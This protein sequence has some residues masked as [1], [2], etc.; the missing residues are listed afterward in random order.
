MNIPEG[1]FDLIYL[2]SNGLFYPNKKNSLLIKYLTAKEEFVLTSPSFR[3]GGKALKMVLES[4]IIDKDIKVE[5][6]LVADKEAIIL[7]LRSTAYGDSFPL[8]FEC[9]DCH[10]KTN[11][12]LNISSLEMVDMHSLPDDLGEFEYTLPMSK[13][14]VKFKPLTV[15]DEE[16]LEK[17][18]RKKTIQGV[19]Y[20]QEITSKYLLQLT[21]IDEHREKSY[22]ESFIK[23]MSLK[24]SIALREYIERTEPGINKRIKLVCS[25]CEKE[26]YDN[27][28]ISSDFLGIT[29]EYRKNIDEEIFLLCYY[30]Q[31][32]Y[33]REQVLKMSVSERKWAIQRISEE[34]E[35]K[36]KAE[37]DAAKKA[38]GS[39]KSG[40][41]R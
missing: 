22:I 16:L 15:A 7:F 36:N 6:L 8:E 28:N 40:R 11:N 13:S 20:K 5:E 18:S 9:S 31:G 25:S 4:V 39:S 12:P 32:G 35:K 10:A 41:T 1:I 33:D 3:E 2:P 38:K 23:R 17:N 37:A 30:G 27:L 29:P 14:K 24:D 21:E 26:Y 19:E 34:I